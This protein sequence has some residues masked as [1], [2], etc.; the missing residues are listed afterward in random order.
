MSS[1]GQFQ[2]LMVK[3]ARPEAGGH[4]IIFLPTLAHRHLPIEVSVNQKDESVAYQERLVKHCVPSL[5]Q[6]KELSKEPCRFF[7]PLTKHLTCLTND[8]SA[9]E[10]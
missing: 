10:R 4:L 2:K 8:Q 6:S 9:L 5:K 1:D 7:S 3:R